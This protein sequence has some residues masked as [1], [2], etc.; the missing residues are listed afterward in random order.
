M[1]ERVTSSTSQSSNLEICVRIKD[2]PDVCTRDQSPRSVPG[3]KARC[4]EPTLPLASPRGEL[5]G[6]GPPTSVQTLLGI[7]ANPLHIGR[8]RTGYPMYVYCNIYC[9]PAK[10]QGRG[11]PTFFR[12]GDA[13]GHPSRHRCHTRDSSSLSSYLV[14]LCHT[15]EPGTR[16]Q[17]TTSDGRFRRKTSLICL[18]NTCFL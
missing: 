6:S 13:T 17:S 3:G 14:S 8:G 12:A 9:S 4:Q 5:M 10:K 2:K 18:R 11:P 15:V 16:I 1:G 7:T